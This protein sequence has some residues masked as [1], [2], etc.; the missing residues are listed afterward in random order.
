MGLQAL[1][2]REQPWGGL[3]E[4]EAEAGSENPSLDQISP[5]KERRGSC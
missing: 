3:G 1:E 4:E 5:E 2:G